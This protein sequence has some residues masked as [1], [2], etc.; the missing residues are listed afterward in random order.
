MSTPHRGLPP[1]AAMALPTQQASSSGAPPTPR[2]SQP[3]HP[4]HHGHHQQQQQHQH[5]HQQRQQHEQHQ[6][7]Q[8]RQQ[9]EQ[10]QQRQPN[11][12]HQ[13]HQQHQ[14]QHEQHIQHQQHQQHHPHHQHHQQHHHQQHA[15]L[16]H[17][18]QSQEL[19]VVHGQPWSTLPPPPQNWHGAEEAT[20]SWLHTRAEEERTKQEEEKSRR[21][22][23]RLERR[24]VE[25]DM[26]R[27]SIRGG[28]PPPMIPLVFA[29]MASGGLPQAALDWAQKLSS[30][31]QSQPL[32]LLPAQRQRSPEAQLRE[33][34]APAQGPYPSGPG[35]Q[36][37]PPP[38]HGSYSSY[39]ASPS[40][41]R[42][43]TVSGVIGRTVG[44][45]NMPPYA[46]QSGG[47]SMA[48]PPYGSGSHPSH[49]HAQ[50]SSPSLYFHH[51]QPPAA[52]SGS[53]T[54]IRPGSPS[55]D[56]SRKRKVSGPQSTGTPGEQRLR[57]PPPFIQ[58]TLSN[59]PPMRRGGHKRQKSS[60]VSWYRPGTYH[61][62]EDS[63]RAPGPPRPPQG[64][65]PTRDVKVEY[66]RQE[67]YA[68]ES[69]RHSV[70]AL[71]TH[72]APVSGP[73]SREAPS[74]SRYSSTHEDDRPGPRHREEVSLR[75][76]RGDSPR[77]KS[78]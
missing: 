17:H 44:A 46:G 62:V 16:A 12:Q 33:S 61:N 60:D 13:Q 18:P 5:Q 72:D 9:H 39:P 15:P 70:S 28:I 57:S 56:A 35:H 66:P 40:R 69:S 41:P 7:H 47:S 77:R 10:H 42:G 1:P 19:S 38:G 25:L 4:P 34:H 21:E 29:G 2:P 31:P 11:E 51:W 68:G 8:Q 65:T 3:P 43:Q 14:H 58:T 64:E 30:S 23:L 6:Q 76:E 67:R 54:S 32:Q 75:R 50:D 55:G 73:H 22:S 48:G 26:L 52:Q 53:G 37:P 59:P 27:D 74:R 45:P 49:I 78:D 24:R 20:K 36:P 71:I 63:E